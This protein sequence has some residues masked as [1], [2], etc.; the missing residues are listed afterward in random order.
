MCVGIL[1]QDVLESDLVT[2]HLHHMN[3]HVYTLCFQYQDGHGNTCVIKLLCTHI[4]YI[5]DDFQN[6]VYCGS[7]MQ[8]RFLWS[9]VWSTLYPTG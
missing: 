7:E 3:L 6:G 8:S 5:F 1:I 9:G 2:A 4:I